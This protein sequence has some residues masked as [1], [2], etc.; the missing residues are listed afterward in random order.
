[1]NAQT[2]GF[3][4]ANPNTGDVTN[5]TR[6]LERAYYER[7]LKHLMEAG[8]IKLASKKLRGQMDFYN[9]DDNKEKGK[10]DLMDC[11]LQA[12]FHVVGGYQYLKELAAKEIGEDADFTSMAA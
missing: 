1:M 11:L 10:G 9:P 6:H 3:G 5:A 8:L 7:I 4:T 2:T 12:S